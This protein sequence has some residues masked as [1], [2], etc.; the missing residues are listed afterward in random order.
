MKTYIAFLFSF[1][2]LI[3]CT[4]NNSITNECLNLSVNYHDAITAIDTQLVD[5]ASIQYIPLKGHKG[6][7]GDISKLIVSK[8]F[9]LLLDKQQ[10]CIWQFDTVG[11]FLNLISREGKGPEEYREIDRIAYDFNEHVYVTGYDNPQKKVYDFSGNYLN[12]EL[13][14]YCPLDI[15]YIDSI[16]YTINYYI[17]ENSD[18]NDKFYLHIYDEKTNVSSKFFSY[19]E[20]LH[21]GFQDNLFSICNKDIFLNM[22]LNDTIYQIINGNEIKQAYYFDFGSEK[23]PNAELMQLASLPERDELLGEKAFQGKICDLNISKTHLTF[24]YSYKVNNYSKVAFVIYNRNNGNLINYKSL[25]FQGLYSDLPHPIATDGDFF[26]SIL[27]PYQ[28]T[29][30]GTKILKSMGKDISENICML[31]YKYKI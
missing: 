30:D 2:I 6:V 23:F 7:V 25:K 3:G 18:S 24:S 15:A 11:T 8:G 22:P 16:L 1:F 4:H 29:K 27:F 14:K 17:P 9:Y 5:L 31:K 13:L 19:K 26:Y 21:E 10:K 20:S 12:T 28:I